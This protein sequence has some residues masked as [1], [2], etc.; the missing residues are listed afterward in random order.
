MMGARNSTSTDTGVTWQQD[1]AGMMYTSA[2]QQP[3]LL[4]KAGAIR[5]P[6]AITLN[7]K[8]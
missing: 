5:L 7:M 3:Q 4:A 8:P 6:G 2:S 1:A